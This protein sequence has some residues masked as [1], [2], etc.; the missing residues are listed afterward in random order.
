MRNVVL[1]FV[2]TSCLTGIITAVGCSS[3]KSST[4]AEGGSSPASSSSSSS[5]SSVA[6]SSSGAGGSGG[7]AGG[8]AGGSAAPDN[9]CNPVTNANCTADAGGCDIGTDQDGNIVGTQCFPGADTVDDCGSCDPTFTNGPFCVPGSSC[10]PV[11]NSMTVGQCAHYCCTDADCG[12]NGS[13]A[14]M[15]TSNMPL[16]TPVSS[17][18]GVCLANPSDA[19]TADG[20]AQGEFVCDAPSPSPSNGSCVTLTPQ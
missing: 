1:I 16:F 18:L 2:A 9:E 4:G 11:G 20:G 19:G 17:T 10:F 3:S 6:S 15:N 7:G 14:M 13:C 12:S 5:S 8:G